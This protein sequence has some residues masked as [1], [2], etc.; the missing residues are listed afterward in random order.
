MT[1]MLLIILI[2]IDFVLIGA[3]MLA[4][5]RQRQIEPLGLMRDIHEEQ[6]LLKDLRDSVLE[7]LQ[8]KQA[9]MRKLYEKVATM[10]TETEVGLKSSGSLLA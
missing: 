7:E 6:R 9:D 2:A 5:K 3:I 1:S 8:S 4:F 10:A